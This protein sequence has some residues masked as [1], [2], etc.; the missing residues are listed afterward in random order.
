[1]LRQARISST[2]TSHKTISFGSLT[3]DPVNAVLLGGETS[4]CRP[5]IF[6]VEL[7][8]HAGQ[9]MDR[10][11]LLKIYAALPM[12]DGSQRRRGYLRLRKTARQRHGALSY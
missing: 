3:I 9:I 6:A 8:T 5:P 11:A 1:M 2:L 7:A 10:D 4:P 12:T